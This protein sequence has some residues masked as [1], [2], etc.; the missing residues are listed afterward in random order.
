M[1]LERARYTG[2]SR[3]T[4]RDERLLAKLAVREAMWLGTG[5]TLV[6]SQ[7]NSRLFVAL[8]RFRFFSRGNLQCER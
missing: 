4:R 6:V 2:A 5:F 7:R 1:S 8:M 3:C